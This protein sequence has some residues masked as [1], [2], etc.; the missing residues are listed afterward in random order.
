VA[1]ADQD[2][3]VRLLDAETGRPRGTLSGHW[4]EVRILTYSPDGRH[5]AGAGAG[6]R[7]VVWDGAGRRRLQIQGNEGTIH[8]LAFAPDG[9][10][11]AWGGQGRRVTLTEVATGKELL[12][13]DAHAASVAALAFSPDGRVLASAGLDRT[14]H[15][16]DAK[17]K[18]IRRLTFADPVVS[19]A[20]SPD[21]KLLAASTAEGLAGQVVLCESASGRRLGPVSGQVSP[22]RHLAFSADGQTLTGVEAWGTV[23]R[24]DVRTRGWR[25]MVGTRLPRATHLALSPDGKRLALAGK[26][27]SLMV[28]DLARNRV[29]RPGGQQP[30]PIHSLAFSPD[31]RTLLTGSRNC[32]LAA[33][34]SLPLGLRGYAN[35]ETGGDMT[36]AV[37]LWDVAS[38]R[39]L[40]N[41]ST[42]KTVALHCA[43]LAPS[44]R[45]VLAGGESGTVWRWDL[46]AGKCRPPLFLGPQA[47]SSWQRAELLR[48]LGVPQF[49]LF[50]QD[51]KAVAFSPDGRLLATAHE[52]PVPRRSAGN[53]LPVVERWAVRL[54]DAEGRSS[55]ELPGEHGP[56]PCVAF[57]PASRTLATNRG[58]AVQLWDATTGRLR[59]T[60]PGRGAVWCLAF[61]PDG[62]LLAAGTA[63]W[64]IHLWDLESGRH[65][66][67]LL[68]HTHA[69]AGL[70][71][72]PDGRTLASASWDATVKL[73]HTAS[74][75][76]LATL[77]AHRGPVHRVAFSPD[78]KTLA[79]GGES[80]EQSG[81]VY[82]WRA[83]PA[84]PLQAAR[85]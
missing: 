64:R 65:R 31:S 35:D 53:R 61:S 39:Q 43:A 58:E 20:F 77:K 85:P 26:G 21:G 66:A 29:R 25:L 80:P 44:G 8:A 16:W 51:V 40:A 15:L 1:V 4:G 70:A 82:L 79:S 69:V 22:A 67:T 32:R 50:N 37:Q 47:R 55:R 33:G 13:T 9:K 11:L 30:G 72:S 19:V 52:D 59:R 6:E 2:H 68:G 14:V 41:L 10:A 71:F 81:E 60:L 23:T 5:L 17:G 48:G 73:W 45:S 42:G 34:R 62:K 27:G 38:G 46:P 18:E 56:V 84:R 83:A 75:Q 63:D 12:S 54:W 7:I 24:W 28:W 36:E 76:E 74:A 78:G 49:C 57:A 3:T